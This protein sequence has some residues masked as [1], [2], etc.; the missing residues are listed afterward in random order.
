[1]RD[2]LVFCGATAMAACACGTASGVASI[3]T[4]WGWAADSSVIYPIL[5]GTG[6]VMFLAGIGTRAHARLIA[7]LG[8]AALAMSILHVVARMCV[9]PGLVFGAH[10][11]MPLTLVSLAPLVVWPLA[12][13]YGAGVAPAPG[14]GGV[15][16][17]AFGATLRDA[18]P[19]RIF[20]ASL[21][22][23]RFYTFYAYLPLGALAAGRTVLRALRERQERK[24]GRRHEIV[25][26][27]EHRMPAQ[28]AERR[29]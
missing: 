2:T 24:H 3:A 11:G 29:A 4:R 9:L 23:W 15:V 7:S 28:S 25:A 19:S 6:A 12:L 8:I 21:I 22:W 16:E 27:G 10:T 17:A 1:M 18:I 5:V 13:Q 26:T 20:G 14:G